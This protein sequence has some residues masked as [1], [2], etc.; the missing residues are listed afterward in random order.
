MTGVLEEEHAKACV[1]LLSAVLLAM[2]QSILVYQ[3]SAMIIVQQ[4]NCIRPLIKEMFVLQAVHVLIMIATQEPL[5]TAEHRNA[6]L[7]ST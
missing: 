7:I 5:L 1:R 4:E 2:T 6:M 3:P